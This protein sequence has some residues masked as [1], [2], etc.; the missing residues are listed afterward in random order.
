LLGLP[1]VAD[2]AAVHTEPSKAEPPK[3]KRRRFQFSLRTLMIFVLLCAVPCGWLAARMQRARRQKS[4]VDEIV[5][6]GGWVEYDYEIDASGKWIPRA[7]P[8]G[9]EW[10]RRLLGSDFFANVVVAKVRTDAGSRMLTGLSRLQYLDLRDAEITDAGLVHVTELS[11]LLVIDL[12]GTKITDAGFEKL[13]RLKTLETLL[14]RGTLA[15]AESTAMLQEA[16]PN[17]RIVR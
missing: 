7:E 6:E 13:E 12:F 10:L 9:P 11:D 8:T 2:N 4:A 15:S 17:C 1:A 5:K 14:L 3:R 16:L